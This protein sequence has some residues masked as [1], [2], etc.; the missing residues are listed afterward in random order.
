MNSDHESAGTGIPAVR[1]DGSQ[2]APE[3]FA[4]DAQQP[5][6]AAPAPTAAAMSAAEQRVILAAVAWAKFQRTGPR[7]DNPSRYL[8]EQHEQNMI[9]AEVRLSGAVAHHLALAD[10]WLNA[11]SHN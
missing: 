5:L 9:E 10:L 2:P 8:R 7:L 4:L 6:P 1:A 11:R 3:L